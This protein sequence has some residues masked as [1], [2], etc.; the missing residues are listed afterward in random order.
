[1][2]DCPILASQHIVLAAEGAEGIPDEYQ[3]GS[4]I[5]QKQ[6]LPPA[7]AISLHVPSIPE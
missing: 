1:M 6:C 4:E 3:D 5:S 7:F 2:E